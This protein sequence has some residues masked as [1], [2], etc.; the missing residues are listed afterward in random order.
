MNLLQACRTHLPAFNCAFEM[1]LKACGSR[2][3]LDDSGVAGVVRLA[4][5]APML[6]FSYHCTDGSHHHIELCIVL[7]FFW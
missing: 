2:E 4:I 7:G 3:Q 5:E 6:R 1:P